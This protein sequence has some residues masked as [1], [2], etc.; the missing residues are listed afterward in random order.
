MHART[1]FTHVKVYN[2]ECILFV[3]RGF[4][5]CTLAIKQSW[6]TRD[7]PHEQT[8][9]EHTFSSVT[10]NH[11]WHTTRIS[12]SRAHILPSNTRGT[13]DMHHTNKLVASTSSL[14]EL[15]LLRSTT[16]P[17]LLNEKSSFQLLK[18]LQVN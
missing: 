2:V 12:S 16:V 11:T 15:P 8:H 7:A 5:M 10:I 3:V 17:I 18:A 4:V 9:H 1:Y 6:H 14:Y 13:P